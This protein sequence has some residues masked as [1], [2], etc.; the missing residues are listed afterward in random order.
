MR[1]EPSP[2]DSPGGSEMASRLGGRSPFKRMAP[3][4]G[5]LGAAETS[6]GSAYKSPPL[7]FDV[8]HGSGLVENDEGSTG[9]LVGVHS[10]RSYPYRYPW[11]LPSGTLY[12]EIFV[13]DRYLQPVV[14]RKT[15][16]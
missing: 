11:G 4:L 3:S 12:P 14:A 2:K 1:R 8:L 9:L 13:P 16:M 10:A 5:A 7:L 6:T 15:P